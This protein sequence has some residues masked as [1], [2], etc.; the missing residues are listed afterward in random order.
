MLSAKAAQTTGKEQSMTL[1][2]F[3]LSLDHVKFVP[4]KCIP[5]SCFTEDGNLRVGGMVC[6]RRDRGVF[7]AGAG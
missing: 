5:E 7:R 2:E 1:E 4:D 3:I 6:R